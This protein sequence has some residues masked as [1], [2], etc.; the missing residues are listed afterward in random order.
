M[1]SLTLENVSFSYPNGFKAVENVNMVIK[2]GERV[3]IIGQNGAGKTTFMR[4][5]VGNLK[6][7]VGN[8][9]LDDHSISKLGS[10]YLEK[11]GY[12]PQHFGYDKNQSVND[13]LHNF[14]IELIIDLH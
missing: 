6:V 10:N 14:Y 11:I 7:S 8:I 13:F 1:N 2:K 12:L 3:A 4:M 9:Y 5:M